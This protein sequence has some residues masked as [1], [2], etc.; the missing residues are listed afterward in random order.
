MRT[1][2]NATLAL[3]ALWMSIWK[4]AKDNICG[5]YCLLRVCP[6]DKMVISK[7]L[8]RNNL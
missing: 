8:Y 6:N 5:I 4:Y 2:E 3:I 7:K 1:L